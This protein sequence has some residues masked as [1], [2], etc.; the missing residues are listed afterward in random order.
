VNKRDGVIWI[1]E[2]KRPADRRWKFVLAVLSRK[3]ADRTV[4]ECGPYYRVRKYVREE[5]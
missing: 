4:R 5:A 2:V 1:V 3:N